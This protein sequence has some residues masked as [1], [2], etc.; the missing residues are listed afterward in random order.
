[1]R[2]WFGARDA[3]WAGF[4][5]AIGATIAGMLANDSGALLLMIGAV[6]CAAAVGV[7]WATREGRPRPRVWRPAGPLT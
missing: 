4:A 5:G 6:L 2:A 1:V 7:A 3:L